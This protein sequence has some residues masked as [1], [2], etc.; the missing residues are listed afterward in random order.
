LD[1]VVGLQKIKVAEEKNRR[2]SDGIL[3]NLGWFTSVT[4][5][6]NGDCL[7]QS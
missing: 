3:Q 5:L 2:F 7:D 4:N 6:Q 1:K